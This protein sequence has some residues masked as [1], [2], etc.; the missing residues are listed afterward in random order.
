MQ[1]EEEKKVKV[2]LTRL[3]RY[4]RPE[5]PYLLL[6]SL[7]AA[8]LGV[9]MPVFAIIFSSVLALFFEPDEDKAKAGVFMYAMLFCALG[10]GALIGGIVQVCL[11]VGHVLSYCSPVSVPTPALAPLDG[12]ARSLEW[13]LVDTLQDS[14]VALC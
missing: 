4:N 14:C 5:W 11:Q 2:S 8:T 1:T 7:A 13:T 6:G 3:L 12:W 9:M 10:V